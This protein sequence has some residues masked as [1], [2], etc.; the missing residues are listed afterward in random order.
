MYTDDEGKFKGEA[1][2]VYF[3]PESV[4]LAI[5]MLDD[6]DFRLGVPGPQ[7]PMRVQPADFSFKS[8]QEAPMKTS[9][10]DK[11]KIIKRTQKLNK[12][13]SAV[14]GEGELLTRGCVANSQIG[15]MMSPLHWWI[16]TPSLRRS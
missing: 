3:R 14:L 11:K 8:Q 7:G 5:Q 15:M 4:N 6:S 1:L 2:V 9:M 16:R 12:Y 10:R 13:G